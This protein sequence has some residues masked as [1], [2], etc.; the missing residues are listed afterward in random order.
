VVREDDYLAVES[1]RPAPGWSRPQYLGWA[2]VDVVLCGH[3]RR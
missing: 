2:P 1:L 3:R